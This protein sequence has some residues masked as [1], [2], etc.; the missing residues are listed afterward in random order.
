[1]VTCWLSRKSRG[2]PLSNVS[3][4]VCE[5]RWSTCV[6]TVCSSYAHAYLASA[7]SATVSA[8]HQ[9]C[10]QD[11]PSRLCKQHTRDLRNRRRDGTHSHAPGAPCVAS[12][13][14]PAN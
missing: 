14:P 12:A 3:L 10:D 5:R 11:A 1:M 7:P 13:E 6:R 8:L 4:A 9:D 2:A